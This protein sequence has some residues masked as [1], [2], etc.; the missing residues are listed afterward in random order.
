M[1]F[2]SRLNPFKK[3]FVLTKSEPD[4]SIPPDAKIRKEK[5]IVDVLESLFEKAAPE[6]DLEEVLLDGEQDEN[7]QPD[8]YT[9]ILCFSKEDEPIYI[10]IRI[11]K[12][13]DVDTSD[14]TERTYNFICHELK[15]KNSTI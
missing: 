14:F 11:G 3:E 1:S 7:Y 4:W 6:F 2:L 12:D 10:K 13:D 9:G 15:E 8:G 5:R